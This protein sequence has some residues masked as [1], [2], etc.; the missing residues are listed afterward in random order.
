MCSIS[1]NSLG[2]NKEIL[3][4]ILS[5]W[6]ACW[7]LLSKKVR[8]KRQNFSSILTSILELLIEAFFNIKNVWLVLSVKNYDFLI[9]K[10]IQQ[11][12]QRLICYVLYVGDVYATSSSYLYAKNGRKERL[13]GNQLYIS[14]VS[15]G[16]FCRYYHKIPICKSKSWFQNEDKAKWRIQFLNCIGL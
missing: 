10:M 7:K 6:F 4:F 9:F 8:M 15:V 16:V 3:F 12:N 13:S 2:I 5:E 1:S 14:D 11:E